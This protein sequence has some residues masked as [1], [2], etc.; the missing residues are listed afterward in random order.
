[1]DIVLVMLGEDILEEGFEGADSQFR[2][3]SLGIPPHLT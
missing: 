1:M 3:F 2:D